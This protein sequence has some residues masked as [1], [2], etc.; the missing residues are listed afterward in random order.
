[1]GVWLSTNA[2]HWVFKCSV[3]TPLLTLISV[4]IV[5][6]VDALPVLAL[7]E[8]VTFDFA[9]VGLFAPEEEAVLVKEFRNDEDKAIA[10]EGD[11]VFSL[12]SKNY[13]KYGLPTQ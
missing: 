3:S 6:F 1:M 7:E 5:K 13:T 9:R 8:R 4:V 2:K 10:V 12:F 11:S